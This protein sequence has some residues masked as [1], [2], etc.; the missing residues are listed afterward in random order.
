[1]PADQ[2]VSFERDD[3]L[4]DRGRADTEVPLHIGF[5]GG[6]LEHVGIDID[7]GQVLAL[8]IGEALP[9]G[10]LRDA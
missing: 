3:H 5:G 8:L 7:E 6:A 4:M 10:V 1:L 2:S 9:S